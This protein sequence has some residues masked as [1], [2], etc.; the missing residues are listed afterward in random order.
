MQKQKPQP[1]GVNGGMDN[2]ALE[3][4]EKKQTKENKCHDV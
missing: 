4:D 3:M 2:K 1:C